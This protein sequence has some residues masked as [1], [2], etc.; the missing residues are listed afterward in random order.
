MNAGVVTN[1]IKPGKMNEWFN[2]AKDSIVP[3]LKKEKG[4]VALMDKNT[5]KSIGYS[6]WGTENDLKSGELNG[7]YQQQIAK[8]SDILSMPPVKG[9]YE[10]NIIE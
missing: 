8:L 10:I 6:I 3:A 9:I 7:S 2:V 5:A 1:Q 4:F